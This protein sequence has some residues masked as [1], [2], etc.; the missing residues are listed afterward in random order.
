[1]ESSCSY[2]QVFHSLEFRHGQVDRQPAFTSW[3]VSLRP[4]YP[5]E[6]DLL[7]R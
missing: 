4:A 3:I 7:E 6:V 2:A 5:A 1:M